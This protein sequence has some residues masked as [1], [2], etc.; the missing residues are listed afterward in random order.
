VFEVDSLPL[1]LVRREIEQHGLFVGEIRTQLR[2]AAV[3]HTF[4]R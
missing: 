4:F 2:F 3:A 1:L